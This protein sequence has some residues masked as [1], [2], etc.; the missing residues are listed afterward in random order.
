MNAEDEIKKQNSALIV[1]L[2]LT[3]TQLNPNP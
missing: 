1:P 2:W 3:Q